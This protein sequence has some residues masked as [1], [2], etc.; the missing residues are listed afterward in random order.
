MATHK[1]YKHFELSEFDCKSLPGSGSQMSPAFLE[2][3]DKARDIAGVSF[4]INSGF[5]TREYNRNLILRGY[6]AS[7]NSSHL[8][9]LAADISCIGSVNRWKII[10]ALIAVGFTRIGIRKDFIHVDCDES[11]SSEV[12]WV[13]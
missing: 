3:L 12:I 11:K 4:K 6:K 1:K 8:V 9:G 5:R 2:K 13:Y 7:R 10:N